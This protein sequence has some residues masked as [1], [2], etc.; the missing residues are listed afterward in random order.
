M[1]VLYGLKQSPWTERGLWA[2]DHHGIAY[3]YHEHVPLLGEV[4]LRRKAG[5][6]K[7]GRASVPLLVDG[8]E[9]FQGG[10]AIAKHADKIGGSN[11]LYPRGA[12]ADVEH[13]V[14]LSDRMN[15]AA[16]TLV[17]ARL[18]RSRAAQREALPAFL[19][20]PVRRL[21]A[22]AAIL[23]TWFLASKYGV[24]RGNE[25]DVEKALAHA[26]EEVRAALAGRTYLLGSFSFADVAIAASLRVVRPEDRASMGTGTREL[27]T[28]RD[29]AQGFEDLLM[30]RDALYAKHR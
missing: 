28:N 2:L 9:V 26:L 10:T 14:A 22:P 17:F 19:P 23:G 18:P 12:E 29:L 25:A 20:S 6:W 21:L 5:S 1:R 3:R 7:N 27:W 13:Y 30:W 11:R 16:R 8:A 24:Q 4:F 15:D